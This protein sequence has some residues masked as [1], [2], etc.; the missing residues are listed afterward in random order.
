MNSELLTPQPGSRG[1]N[2]RWNGAAWESPA[3]VVPEPAGGGGVSTPRILCDRH[4]RWVAAL[5]ESS[6]TGGLSVMVARWQP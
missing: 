4:G 6:N 1:F 2:Y 3:P 5:L